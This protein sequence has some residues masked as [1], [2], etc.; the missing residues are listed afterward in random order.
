MG[1]SRPRLAI[2]HLNGEIVA[3]TGRYAPDAN[4]VTQANKFVVEGEK[5]ILA[6]PASVP[7]SQDY[8][9]QIVES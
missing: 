7:Q 6:S 9:G 8:G 2:D 3:Q 4:N 1:A 5:T